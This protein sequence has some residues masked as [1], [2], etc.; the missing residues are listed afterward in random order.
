MWRKPRAQ[1]FLQARLFMNTHDQSHPG[2]DEVTGLLNFYRIILSE[3]ET[4]FEKEA[5]R[6][7]RPDTINDLTQKFPRARYKSIPEWAEAVAKEIMHGSLLG[8]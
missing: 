1:R 8:F 7:L 6:F 2:F 4:A 3:P 5:R